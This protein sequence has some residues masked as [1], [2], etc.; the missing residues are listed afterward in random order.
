[1]GRARAELQF[2]STTF[3]PESEEFEAALAKLK[4]TKAEEL[5]N[6]SLPQQARSLQDQ[7]S[8]GKRRWIEVHSKMGRIGTEICR[9][10]ER[11]SLLDS[12]NDRLGDEVEEMET[13]LQVV[14]AAIQQTEPE[15]PPPVASTG[16][17]SGSPDAFDLRS[18]DLSPASL[19][20]ML[21]RTYEALQASQLPT[22]SQVSSDALMAVLQ[23]VKA[24]APPA[25]SAQAPPS[26]SEPP[27]P[28]DEGD[29]EDIRGDAA[30]PDEEEFIEGAGE[31]P[32][33]GDSAEDFEPAQRRRRLFV[34]RS[35]PK[36]S[37]AIQAS[38]VSRN[39]Q[40]QSDRAPPPPMP[41]GT[42]RGP[43]ASFAALRAQQRASSKAKAAPR[44]DPG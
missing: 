20:L 11:F 30:D 31:P 32:Y 18:M 9:L 8:S 37:Q 22:L 44:K 23:E 4:R 36:I 6:K 10:T 39:I 24:A 26:A 17:V 43:G 12:Q 15:Q 38:S 21:Q 16:S 14:Q 41:V 40:P 3:G 2:Y 29:M 28:D 13:Q 34:P 35:S 5:A 42:H 7:I 1:V 19:Q 33:E 27:V 25:Q